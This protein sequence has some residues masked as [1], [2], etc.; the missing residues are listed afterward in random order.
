M[1]METNG[2]T[3][4]DRVRENTPGE[5][6]TM[7]DQTV[8][9]R[10][11][12]YR[13]LSISEINKRLEKLEKEWDIERALGIYASSIG[14]ASIFLGAFRRRRWYLLSFV[15]A[16]FLLMDGIRGW[17]PPMIPLRRMGFRTKAEID[18]E[19]YALKALRGDFDNISS[20]AS[21]EDILASFRR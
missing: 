4:R 10:M 2:T 16:G 19:I 11:S 15:A 21:P 20:T 17:A 13:N 6:N 14:L 12:R 9:D 5:K 3:I 18:E 1:A 7:M 8:M